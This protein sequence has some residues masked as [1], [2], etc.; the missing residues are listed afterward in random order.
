MAQDQVS[1]QETY[2]IEESKSAAIRDELV[3]N[4][5]QAIRQGKRLGVN[6]W[7]DFKIEEEDVGEDE[8]VDEDQDEWDTEE[9]IL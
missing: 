3:Q 8:G 6:I 2:A 4:Q 7:K 1:I 9:G 5:F